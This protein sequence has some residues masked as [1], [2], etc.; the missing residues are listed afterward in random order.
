MT[1]SKSSRGG[2]CSFHRAPLRESQVGLF[3]TRG[4]ILPITLLVAIELCHCGSINVPLR[5]C[6]SL[7]FSFDR[8]SSW[9]SCFSYVSA[10]I[11]RASFFVDCIDMTHA[12][13]AEL[14][15]RE[16]NKN[17]FDLNTRRFKTVAEIV[18]LVKKTI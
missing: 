15:P 11:L 2:G 5:F 12:L 18:R 8:G 10:D 9:W 4:S 7:P 1:M 3:T 6:F 13:L 16:A 17:P 14:S